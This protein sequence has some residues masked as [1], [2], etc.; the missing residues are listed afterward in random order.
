MTGEGATAR[1]LR[2]VLPRARRFLRRRRRPLTR[3][4]AFSVL[5]SAQTFLGGYG[6]ARA[7]DD[8]FLAGDTATG[9]L[10][11]A[12]GAVAVIA[13]GPVVRGVFRHLADLVEPLRDGLLR[14]VVTRALREATTG[15][16][17]TDAGAVSRLTSQTEA[18]RDGF[19]GLVLTARTFGVTLLGTVAGL[20]VL[21]PLLLLVVLP[22]LAL[23][24]LLFCLS[25]GPTALRQH[26]SLEADEALA[27]GFG[28]TA[29]GLRDVVACGG[30]RQRADEGEALTDAAEA[31]ARSL[32]RWAAL[33]PLTLGV[34]GQ[35]PVVLLLVCAPWLLRGGVSAGELLGAL[36]YLTQWLLPA[37]NTLAQALGTAATRLLVVLDRLTHDPYAAPDPARPDPAHVPETAVPETAAAT[38]P[39]PA[40]Y[41]YGT[42]TGARVGPRVELRGVRFAYGPGARPVLDGLDAVVEPGECLAVV[43]PSGIGKSTLAALTAGL[44]T[45][46]A[47]Q[48]LVDGRP[49]LPPERGEPALRRVLIPQQ[50]YVFSGTLRENLLYL[51]PDGAPP[52]DVAASARAV[53]LDPLLRRLGGLDATVVPEAL[54]QGERQLVALARAHLSPAPLVLLDEATC[55]LDPAAEARAERAFARRP[56]T[57][58]VIAHRLSSARRADRVLV[59]DGLRALSGGHRELLDSSPLYRELFGHWEAPRV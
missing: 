43:G 8:G 46:A 12:A 54:S 25:L 39:E 50:A 38:P 47:G 3:L 32:A 35:L 59:L 24:S 57:V 42:G 27:A 36:T 34:A 23:G 31:A 22:P 26:R 19:A 56:G 53:G 20:V 15:D 33:R 1:P 44:L 13:G 48:V 11:L 2:R 6:V 41:A 7:L 17:R 49:P 21:D 9:L 55:H 30:E 29:R 18:A 45:P 4:A 5:E 40:P 14:L 51:C 10:W 16:G 58:V 37:L 52:A 28:A